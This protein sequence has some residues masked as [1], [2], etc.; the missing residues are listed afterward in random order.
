MRAVLSAP[1]VLHS[2]LFPFLHVKYSCAL[3]V[4]LASFQ[5]HPGAH[6][7]LTSIFFFF[8]CAPPNFVVMFT[9]LVFRHSFCCGASF[10][11]F[12]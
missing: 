3:I 8:L 4:V 10:R 12:K 1:L 11:P 7:V 2:V 5:C 9:P 6:L